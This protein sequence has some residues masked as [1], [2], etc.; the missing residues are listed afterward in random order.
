LSAV[1]LDASIVI[2]WLLKEPNIASEIDQLIVDAL[3]DG[4]AAPR[5]LLL[6]APNGLRTRVRRGQLTLA[7]RDLMLDDFLRLPIAW[8]DGVDPRVLMALSDRHDL[9][10]YDAAY[11]EL[12]LRGS[13]PLAT[14]DRRLAAAAK[15]SGVAVAP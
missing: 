6:E 3:G 14:L 11:L 7:E 13:L 4:F 15:T 8:D 1:V 12:A 10:L 5:L 9:T 2:A